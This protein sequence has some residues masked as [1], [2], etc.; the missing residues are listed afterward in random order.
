MN[1]ALPLAIDSTEVARVREILTGPWDPALYSQHSDAW[2]VG[3]LDRC[4]DDN[5]N[6]LDMPVKLPGGPLTLPELPA[7]LVALTEAVHEFETVLWPESVNMYAYLTVNQGVVKGGTSQRRGGAHV[8]GMQGVRYP[9]KLPACH[10]YLWATAAPTVIFSHPFDFTGLDPSKHNFFR[11]CDEQKH[12]GWQPAAGDIVLT[13]AYTVHESPVLEEDTART[14][15][16][17]EYSHKRAD[18][19]G[20]TLNPALDTSDWD[21]GPRPIPEHLV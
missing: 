17:I 16:R 20:N 6:V 4:V 19:I 1:S 18:R 15:V 2:K 21:Y 3:H 5:I 12:D 11:A 7:W 9:V 8:D 10:Q 14:F 13:T